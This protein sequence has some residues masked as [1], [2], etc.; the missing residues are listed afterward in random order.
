[1][2]KYYSPYKNLIDRILFVPFFFVLTTVFAV[3]RELMNGVVSSKYFWFYA[4]MGLISLTTPLTSLKQKQSVR[5]VVSD[6]LLNHSEN[7]TKLIILVLLVV[8]YFLFR[9]TLSQ[10]E[11]AEKLLYFAII[12]TGLVEAIWELRQ[13]YGFETSN[14]SLFNIT[15]SFFNPGP[16]AGFLSIIFPLALWESLRFL[17]TEEQRRKTFI[18]TLKGTIQY[19]S[20]FISFST[21]VFILLVVPAAMSRASW[22]A[23]ITGS[24]CVLLIYY[25]GKMDVKKF[26]RNHRKKTSIIL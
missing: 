22:I 5:F 3:D 10:N 18:K 2:E 16:Y 24:L 14:H 9:I 1:M 7:T 19:L 13:L 12:A 6:L 23:M 21:I 26:I 4:S 15:G 20:G 25:K 8:L 17:E 11:H